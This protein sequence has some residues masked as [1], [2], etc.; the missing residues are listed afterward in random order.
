MLVGVRISPFPDV[1]YVDGPDGANFSVVWLME[2]LDR[3]A[4]LNAGALLC[5]LHDHSGKPRFSATD[6]RT[7]ES[8]MAKQRIFNPS[9]PY[10]AMVVSDDDCTAAVAV[11]EGLV[12]VRVVPVMSN[13]FGERS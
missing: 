5:H 11:A 12:E 4:A 3:A 13:E 2:S 9:L 6:V 10:G 8:V 1:A 7:N